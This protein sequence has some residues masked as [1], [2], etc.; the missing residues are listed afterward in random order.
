MQKETL[1][2]ILS[3][4]VILDSI[5]VSIPACHAGDRGSIPR[6]GGNNFI[7]SYIVPTVFLFAPTGY[8]ITVSIPFASSEFHPG[9]SPRTQPQAAHDPEQRHRSLLLRH[10]RWVGTGITCTMNRA[11]GLGQA[12]R[13]SSCCHRSKSSEQQRRNCRRLFPSGSPDW[14]FQGVTSPSFIDFTLKKGKD[15]FYRD[16]NS[17]RRIQ[18]PKC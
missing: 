9:G 1:R 13:F 2:Q 4:Y 18:S 12:S 7:F 5:V 10:L 17:D 6:Q 15:R 8:T 11:A 16:L 14:M 3:Y